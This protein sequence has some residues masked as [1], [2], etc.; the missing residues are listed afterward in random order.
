MTKKH[1]I[2]FAKALKDHARNQDELEYYA[3]L[4]SRVCGELGPRF[5]RGRFLNA[6]GVSPHKQVTLTYHFQ[7]RSET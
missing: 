3:E 4:V 1:F 7:E 2:A 5:D 6:C